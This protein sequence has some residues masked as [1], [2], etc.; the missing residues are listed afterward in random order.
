MVNDFLNSLLGSTVTMTLSNGAVGTGQGTL[1]WIEIAIMRT[2]SLMI[3]HAMFN[4]CSLC[5]VCVG[6]WAE[7]MHS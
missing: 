7:H 6:N 1:F 3:C 5:E 4:V 2:L